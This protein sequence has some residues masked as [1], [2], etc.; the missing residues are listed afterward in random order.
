MEEVGVRISLIKPGDS[1]FSDR[2][3]LFLP[4][5]DC[6][7]YLRG[8]FQGFGGKDFGISCQIFGSLRF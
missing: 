5:E 1:G 4:P 8:L 3:I 6:H 2:E 7:T